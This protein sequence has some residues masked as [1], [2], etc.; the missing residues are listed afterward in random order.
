MANI[1][2]RD[3]ILQ[4]LDEQCNTPKGTIDRSDYLEYLLDKEEKKK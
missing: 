3:E 2:I 1:Y 4:K